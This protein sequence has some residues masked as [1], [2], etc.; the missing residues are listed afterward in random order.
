MK[1]WVIGILFVLVL[2]L[3]V[4]VLPVHAQSSVYIV[5]PGDTL[6][7]IAARHGVSV[8]ALATTNGLQWNSWVYAGQRLTIPARGTAAPAQGAATP[9]S[10]PAAAGG[11]Y[12]VRAGDTLL[13]I[14]ARHGVSVS[15]L[16]AANGLSWNSWVYVGQRL[17][18]PGA[19]GA[20]ASAPAS[21]ATGGVHVVQAGDTLSSLA[22]RYGTTV[23]ALR[24]ANGLTS[25]LIYVGQRLRLS[26]TAPIAAPAQSAPPAAHGAQGEKWIGV[27][28]TT[29]T[30]TAYEG[31]TAVY[32]S[33][34]STGTARTPTVVGTFRI[35]VKYVSTRMR[36]PGYD[37]ANV[38][39]TMYFHGGYGIH[40]TYWHN[41]FGTP[42]SHG[43]V[44]LPTPAA[45]W[46]F[47]WAPVGTKV[48]VHY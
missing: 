2:S 14:A 21:P 37:L 42:M 17:S 16:A 30:V 19:S 32:S 29:Q 23:A 47:N 34:A 13:N 22:R 7:R 9:M 48:V 38:P 4:S 11:T 12:V 27:N 10:A 6:L 45:Q 28:L 36:G 15:N 24:V 44:N 5:Q 35:Y 1:R 43:C 40:G 20:P 33:I 31:R 41:N 18:I 39:Y 8:S 25:D 3:M 26:G 46:F